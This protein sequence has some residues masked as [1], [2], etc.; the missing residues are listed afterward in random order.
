VQ[1][2][3]LAAVVMI[4]L[5]VASPARSQSAVP[6]KPLPAIQLE[7]VRGLP[8]LDG[9]RFSL[10]FSEATPI[11]DVLMLLVR[12]T[13]FS[14]IPSPGLDRRFIG[15][16]K[17]VTLRQAL[18]LI[19]EPMALDYSVRGSVIRVFPRELETRIYNIDHVITQRAGRRSVG[20]STEVIS[21]DAP[22]AFGDL[23]DGL[24]ALLSEE[25]RL[26]VDRTAGL[27]QVVDR[28]S[29]LARVEQYLET[30]MLRSTRQVQIDARVVDVQLARDATGIDW[31]RAVR[32]VSSADTA[33]TRGGTTM[34][35]AS[36]DLEVLLT[37]LRAQGQVDLLASPAVTAMNN[38]P[39]V[40]RVATHEG[41][42]VTGGVALSVTPQ[43][44]VDGTIEMSV[45]ATVTGQAAP[46]SATV[47]VREADTVVRVRQGETVV[48]A[49]LLRDRQTAATAADRDAR[50]KTETVILITPTMLQPRAAAAT[51]GAR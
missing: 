35:V 11:N 9:P 19:L 43:I 44:G 34:I 49:G 14:V 42:T 47:A 13:R 27:L 45:S 33:G 32:D 21:T 8:Q 24:R 6:L 26:N 36:N 30:A 31:R 46:P 4:G 7:L 3:V 10:S 16:L 17:N 48:I 23:A 20:G 15:D 2:G 40:V 38:E 51:A 37:A 18:D 12:D 28:P 1:S 39:A 25:G 29:R 41:P 5:A 50:R 22:D